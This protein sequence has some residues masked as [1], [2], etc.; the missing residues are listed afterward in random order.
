M[1]ARCAATRN[2]GTWPYVTRCTRD[3][4]HADA[5]V[6]RH[7]VEWRDER[8]PTPWTYTVVLE[9]ESGT[10]HTVDVELDVAP[11]GLGERRQEVLDSAWFAKPNTTA[12]WSIKSII[13]P[14]GIEERVW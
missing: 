9:D 14:D 11:A 13:L 4:N 2:P 8:S 12:E 1:S 3:A 5:H 10:E 6:D 7:G